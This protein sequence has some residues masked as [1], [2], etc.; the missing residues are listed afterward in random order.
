MWDPSFKHF[1][2]FA[3]FL[4]MR[5]VLRQKMC[6]IQTFFFLNELFVFLVLNEL[7]F[8]KS[9]RG[10]GLWAVGAMTGELIRT[11]RFCT[12]DEAADPENLGLVTRKGTNL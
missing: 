9:N 4:Y 5:R 10:S 11:W 3:H 6:V 8:C 2:C 12:L 1:Y 7:F